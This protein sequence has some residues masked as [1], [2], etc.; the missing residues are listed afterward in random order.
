MAEK[1]SWQKF[2]DEMTKSP[3]TENIINKEELQ[4]KIVE[5]AEKIQNSSC[6]T[7]PVEFCRTRT[8]KMP[9]TAYASAG[10]DF[11]VPAFDE[12]FVND[13]TEK[14]TAGWKQNIT[15]DKVTGA[16]T[17]Y[18]RPGERISIPSGIKVKFN[19]KDVALIAYNK[20]GVSTK[21]GLVIGACVVDEDYTG[22]VHISLINTSNTDTITLTEGEKAVQFL[23]IPIVPVRETSE[24]TPEEYE[25]YV[26]AL[27]SER[28]EK[29]CGSSN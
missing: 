9:V 3:Q 15:F 17:M 26:Q 22:E 6:P 20:S 2:L 21:K 4:R 5:A 1:T 29:W 10:I 19:R 8:V 11:Y 25:K 16:G 12:Q 28:G 24:V 13:L 14:S 18:I 23:L 7:Y 27:G